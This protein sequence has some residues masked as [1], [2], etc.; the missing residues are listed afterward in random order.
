MWSQASQCCFKAA[1]AEGLATRIGASPSLP[2][3][4]QM[5]SHTSVRHDWLKHPSLE[6]SSVNIPTSTPQGRS[7]QSHEL[8]SG[9]VDASLASWWPLCTPGVAA[10]CAAASC[11]PLE[12]ASASACA[13]AVGGSSLLGTTWA[14]TCHMCHFL[15]ASVVRTSQREMGVTAD[16]DRV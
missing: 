5:H 2:S 12:R 6:G 13:L 9:G 16:A 3:H 11:L 8:A 7:F 15:Q 1:V 10:F 14:S 4:M